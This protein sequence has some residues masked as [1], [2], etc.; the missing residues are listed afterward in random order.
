MGDAHVTTFDGRIFMHTGSCQYVLAK[1]RGN[2]KFTVTLQYTACGEV[3]VCAWACVWSEMFSVCL[4]D[5]L[6]LYVCLRIS[7]AFIQWL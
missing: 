1:S 6:I 4:M 2:T 7:R 5:C 3:C